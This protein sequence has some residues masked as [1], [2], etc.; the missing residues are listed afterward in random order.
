MIWSASFRLKYSMYICSSFLG[1]AFYSSIS[2]PPTRSIYGIVSKNFVE[3]WWKKNLIKITSNIRIGR[4][5][6]N[7]SILNR[8]SFFSRVKSGSHLKWL[9]LFKVD[10]YIQSVK[11]ADYFK[12]GVKTTHIA[13]HGMIRVWKFFGRQTKVHKSI[14][15][16][17]RNKLD[18]LEMCWAFGLEMHG[19][20]C[21][22][23]CGYV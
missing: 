5:F 13:K 21:V 3:S 7:F 6:M 10:E 4:I 2:P 18:W 17:R 19:I 20:H 9:T 8:I 16:I 14:W 15:K 1:T 22:G 11:H 12:F 23:V